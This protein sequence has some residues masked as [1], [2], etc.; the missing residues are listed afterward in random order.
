MSKRH[1]AKLI[2]RYSH[3]LFKAHNKIGSTGKPN[4]SRD[5]ADRFLSHLQKLFGQVEAL[6]HHIFI[7]GQAGMDF[8]LSGEMGAAHIDCLR[9]VSHSDRQGQ[10]VPDKLGGLADKI[11]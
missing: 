2:G 4:F 1:L 7:G 6:I 8:K 10:I 11:I 5:I 3:P 9:Y